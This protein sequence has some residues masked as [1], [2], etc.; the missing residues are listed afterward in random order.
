LFETRFKNALANP[1]VGSAYRNSILKCG[2][3]KDAREMLKDFLGLDP[4]EKAFLKRK[5]ITT[6][7]EKKVL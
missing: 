6:K 1:R 5:G 7:N 4:N 3:S 2:G